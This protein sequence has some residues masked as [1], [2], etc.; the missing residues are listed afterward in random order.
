MATTARTTEGTAEQPLAN[1]KSHRLASSI[2]VSVNR[3]IGLISELELT[4]AEFNAAIE[5]LTDVGHSTDRRRNEWAVLVDALALSTHVHGLNF[6]AIPGITPSTPVGPFYRPDA[7]DYMN[8]DSISKDGKGACL[9]VDVQVVSSNGTPLANAL[10]E[11]W[12]ANS[13]GLYEN[14][15]PDGQPEHNLR[16]KFRTGEDGR[17]AFATVRPAGYTLPSDG[18][19]GN[20]F[21]RLGR[22]MARPAHIHFRISSTDHEPLV[23][24]VFDADDPMIEDD[25]QNVV[26]PEL[27]RS[28]GFVD[29]RESGH[30]EVVFTLPQAE[31]DATIT[32]EKA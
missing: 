8:G 3:L 26:R 25:V 10:V 1:F 27:V 17:C 4:N 21:R 12:H 23:T 20:L 11:V 28:F 22:T 30:L 7:P 9:A 15:D 16:G 31:P 18:P 5:F 13:E 2:D 14:Q 32:L 29:G 24:Q 19:V 6:P